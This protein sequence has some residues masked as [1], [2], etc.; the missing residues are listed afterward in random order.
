MHQNLIYI[1]IGLLYCCAFH[2]AKTAYKHGVRI[3]FKRYQRVWL[4]TGIFLLS[5]VLVPEHAGFVGLLA[6]SLILLIPN[7]ALN[8]AVVR[9]IRNSHNSQRWLKLVNFL[10]PENK[11]DSWQQRLFDDSD[12]NIAAMNQVLDN[13]DQH[14]GDIQPETIAAMYCITH[15]F[16]ELHQWLEEHSNE[17]QTIQYVIYNIRLLGERGELNAM[18]DFFHQHK[19]LIHDDVTSH[20][21]P[22]IYLNLHAFSGNVEAVEALLAKSF[23]SRD[24]TINAF[25]RVT[26]LSAAGR[27]NELAAYSG[28]QSRGVAYRLENLCANADETIDQAHRD[29]LNKTLADYTSTYVPLPGANNYFSWFSV[30]TCIATGFILMH[31]LSMSY[32]GP[33]MYGAYTLG[34]SYPYLMHLPADLWRLVSASFIPYDEMEF[35]FSLFCLLTIA[36]YIEKKLG[37]IK[38]SLIFL[39][40]CF[41]SNFCRYVYD[42]TF[43]DHLTIY[44]GTTSGMMALAG[45]MLPIIANE[46]KPAEREELLNGLFVV[47]LLQIVNAYCLNSVDFI[48]S[49]SGF[50]FGLL[51]S[52][53]L[54]AR[55]NATA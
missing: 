10:S 24:E 13:L 54:L 50:I 9:L 44:M 35:V 53:P 49:S 20:L 1:F 46:P 23:S 14:I 4:T 22:F 3:S 8:Y 55:K 19:V 25:T 47:S 48:T 11:T 34:A 40:C 41:L 7:I 2:F 45:M 26:A 42:L 52:W 30:T 31:V 12:A 29:K 6:A 5:L 51:L 28:E 32:D 17:M 39:A 15:R 37:W 21:K 33:Y 18:I 16:S 27:N 36:P 38:F 43:V